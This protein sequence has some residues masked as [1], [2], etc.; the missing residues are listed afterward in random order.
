ML[1]STFEKRFRHA[2]RVAQVPIN[3]AFRQA[4][5]FLGAVQR[6]NPTN[7]VRLSDLIYEGV[8]HNVAQYDIACRNMGVR[9][10][11]DDPTVDFKPRKI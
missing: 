10:M 4:Y 5:D 2:M 6:N 11:K 9:P 7:Q 8:S 1:R 3:A